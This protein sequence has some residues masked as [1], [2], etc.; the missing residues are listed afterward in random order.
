MR[1]TALAAGA[2]ATLLL[3]ACGGGDDTAGGNGAG[4]GDGADGGG[5]AAGSLFGDAQELA[6]AATQ[7]T[8]D[9]MSYT[10]TLTTDIGGVTATGEGEGIHDGEDSRASVTMDMMGQQIE[11]ISIG[12][13][14]YT[15]MPAE[16]GGDP[17]RPW[18]KMDLA[19]DGDAA[20][21]MLE[22]NDPATAMEWVEKAGEITGS[23]ETTLDGEQVTHYTVDLDYQKM[24]DDFADLTGETPP[25]QLREIDATMP[26]E[27]WLN[28][29]QLPVKL[30][31]DMSE[32]MGQVAQQQGGGAEGVP[33]SAGM[34][35]TYDNWG[36]PVDI[37]EPPADQ[38]MEMPTGLPN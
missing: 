38:V 35:M 8:A 7:S 29:D 13:T 10:F 33:D 27:I 26:M 36:E 24:M 32:M 2:A 6:G 19:E 15:K 1:K 22:Y 37:T 11:T 31:M 23:E 16:M 25:E 18:M 28:S 5:G 21:A 3:A 4:G 17:N 30:T 9:R 12:T 34:E 20:A 14:T